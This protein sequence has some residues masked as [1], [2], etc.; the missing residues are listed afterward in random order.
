MED[1]ELY[2][3]V[4]GI[5]TP[6]MVSDVI[7]EI[8]KKT[9]TIRVEYD[10]TQ[11]CQCPDCGKDTERYDHN[12]RRWRHLD[13]CQMQ[14]IIECDVPRV[15]C[16]EHGVKQI[17]V[18]WAESKSHFTAMFEALVINWLKE[19]SISAVADLC[20]LSWDR[21]AGIQERA[22]ERGLQRR[23][24]KPLKNISIDETS[25]QKRH[26]YV[27]ML[28]DRDHDIVLD[29]LDDRKAETIEKWLKKWIKFAQKSIGYFLKLRVEVD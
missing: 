22:V 29:I 16:K 3:N 10:K 26:E 28:I 6:W 25:Y 24:A 17:S 5:K 2:Q 8:P 9:V 11:P 18:P 15:K 14:T 19:A 13:T 4:L 7:L 12:K 21:V 20:G 23:K 1:K 27:T